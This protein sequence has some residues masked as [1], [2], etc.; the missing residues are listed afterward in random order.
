MHASGLQRESD[1]CMQ[2]LSGYGMGDQIVPVG[3]IWGNNDLRITQCEH[4]HMYVC[5]C[6]V[7][8]TE[9]D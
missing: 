1:Q 8:Y 4:T 9:V 7:L 6:T 2:D 5:M 3:T